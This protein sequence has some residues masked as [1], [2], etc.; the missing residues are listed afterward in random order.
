MFSESELLEKLTKTDLFQDFSEQTEENSVILQEILSVLTLQHFSSGQN[1]IT[2]G[3][4]GFSVYILIE[5]DV[6]VLNTTPSKESFA[7]VNLSA[8][9]HVSFGEIALID[10]DKRS[11]TVLALTD[12]KVL[13]LTRDAY[14]KICEKNPLIGFRLTTRIA[15]NVSASLRK[16]KKDTLVLYQALLEEIDN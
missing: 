3:E 5:G 10:N 2:E 7:V 13:E 15:R 6:R 16:V 12:C 4:E 8:E 9:Q 1:I 14:V 11:A